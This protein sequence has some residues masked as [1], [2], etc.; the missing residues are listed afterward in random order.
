MKY[1]DE[2]EFSPNVIRY[3]KSTA[4]FTMA[5]SP[6]VLITL[7]IKPDVFGIALMILIFGIV[8]IGAFVILTADHKSK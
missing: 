1:Q 7:L 8:I 4:I 5:F 3:I 2:P 6:I